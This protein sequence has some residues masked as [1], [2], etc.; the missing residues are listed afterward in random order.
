MSNRIYQVN[1]LI[2]EE[3]GKLIQKE[4]ADEAG[5]GTVKEVEVTTDLHF[6]TVWISYIGQ[7]EL[8]YFKLLESKRKEIQ[9]RLNRTLTM[10]YVPL[11]EF[12][13]DHSGEY[14]EQIDEVI[15]SVGQ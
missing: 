10:K 6:A 7:N 9:K 4:I 3:V 1:A 11:V 14:A 5:F 13:Q 15:R 8:G 2:K 12:K